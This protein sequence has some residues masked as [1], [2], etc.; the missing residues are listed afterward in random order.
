MASPYSDDLREKFIAAYEAG[1]VGL[2]KLASTFQVSRAW[3]ES[4][5]RTK[6]ETGSSQRPPGG[7]RGFPSRLTPEIRERLA[8]Q[9][10]KQPDA[11]VNELREWVQQQEG[12][13]ISQQRLSAVIFEMGL[14]IKKAFPPVNRTVRKEYVDG[15][16]GEPKQWRSTRNGSCFWMNVAWQRT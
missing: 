12:V 14:R 3:A 1:N 16:S 13:A 9:I 10:G 15:N 6:R 7:R 11:T 2:E 4:V 5:W 8:T